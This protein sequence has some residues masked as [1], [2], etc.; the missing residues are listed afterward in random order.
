MNNWI[1]TVL[2]DKNLPLQALFRIGTSAGGRQAKAIIAIDEKNG[3]ISL[4]FF[5]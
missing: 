3:Q 1:E 4:V 5:K 2:Q